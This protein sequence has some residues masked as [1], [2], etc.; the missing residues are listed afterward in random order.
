LIWS[1]YHNLLSI[2]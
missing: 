1:L 2:M